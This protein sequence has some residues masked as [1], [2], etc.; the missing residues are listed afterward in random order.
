MA[1]KSR[2]KMFVSVLPGEQVE[3]I[4]ADDGRITEY[5]VE[6]VHQAKTRGNIYKGVIHN[7]DANLQAAF[8]NYGA[9]KNGFL[10]I[11]EVHPEYYQGAYKVKK[12]FKY[13][14]IQQILRPGQEV[15][16]QVVKEPTGKKGAFMSTYL[17]PAGPAISCSPRAANRWACRARSRPTTSAPSSRNWWA[18]SSWTRAWASSCAPPPTR[19]P[20]PTSARISSSS[21]ACGRTCARRAPPSSPRPWSTRRWTWP[22]G[23][24]ATT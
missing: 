11:D 22:P 24:C 14:P 3:V 10:Q 9:A 16:V 15:L 21:S 12:G 23:P 18:T 1:T 13:P 4:L 6:M 17:S 7:I 8:I 2:T 5:Y 20:R 19:P